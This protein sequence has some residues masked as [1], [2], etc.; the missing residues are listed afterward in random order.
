MEGEYF[1]KQNWYYGLKRKGGL[2]IGV[3]KGWLKYL[4]ESWNQFG[5]LLGVRLIGMQSKEESKGKE[6][7]SLWSPS[8]ESRGQDSS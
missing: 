2:A 1:K 8:F 4:S 7:T 6:S 5:K 3:T